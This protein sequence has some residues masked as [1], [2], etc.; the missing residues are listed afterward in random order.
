MSTTEFAADAGRKPFKLLGLLREFKLALTRISIALVLTSSLSFIFADRIFDFFTS[1]A[2]GMTFY[3]YELAGMITT[4]FQVCIFTGLAL[5]TP[6][7]IFEILQLIAPALEPKERRY[8]FLTAPA[9]LFLALLGVAYT[10]YVFMPPAFSILF[11]DWGMGVAPKINISSYVAFVTKSLFGIGLFFQIPVVIYYLAKLKVVSPGAL[12]KQW[13]WAVIGA[14]VVA[15]VITPTGNPMQQ[16]LYDIILMDTGFVV[17]IPILILY[18]SSVLII[19]MVRRKEK[20][21]ASKAG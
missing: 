19:W 9:M 4:Y 5:A 8:L 2:A 21:A 1:R 10:Y 16:E 17:S 7:L 11:A 6:Y 13:R 20:P 15:A 12:L 3:N 14:V 18:F